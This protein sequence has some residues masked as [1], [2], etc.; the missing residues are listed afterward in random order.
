MLKLT[1]T[2]SVPSK[3]NSR[4]GIR[5]KPSAKYPNGRNINIPN[6]RYQEWNKASSR[7]VST[8]VPIVPTIEQC[9]SIEIAFHMKDRRPRDLTN[10][11]ESVMDLLVDCE[12]IKD[13]CWSITGLLSL[14]PCGVDKENPRAEV[15][16]YY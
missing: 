4:I 12:I 15:L 9:K 8:Q 16:I 2:G 1:I 14:I 3:K 7:Q 13:D 11:A 5:L 6:N 10:M